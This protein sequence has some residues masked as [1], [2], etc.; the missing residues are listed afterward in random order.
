MLYLLLLASAV[1][2]ILMSSCGYEFQIPGEL[3]IK[4]DYLATSIIDAI[5]NILS[6]AGDVIK[7]SAVCYILPS[8]NYHL[9]QVS[10][11]TEMAIKSHVSQL[12]YDVYSE[13]DRV[14]PQTGPAHFL[15]LDFEITNWIP[16]KSTIS[17]VTLSRHRESEDLHFIDGPA[18]IFNDLNIKLHATCPTDLA[19]LC[20]TD[21]PVKGSDFRFPTHYDCVFVHKAPDVGY[22]LETSGKASLVQFD[23]DWNEWHTV[24]V[25]ELYGVCRSPA[26]EITEYL[27]AEERK[28]V[29]ETRVYLKNEEDV[30]TSIKWAQNNLT[31]WLIVLP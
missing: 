29:N 30:V 28:P 25:A 15:T 16:G 27:A 20:T 8:W 3:P 19:W 31:N 1:A 13:F 10:E 23:Q 26:A 21:E 12:S 17:T 9:Y 24:C 22:V 7:F 2:A 4:T 11:G 6:G 14:H 18:R 5:A